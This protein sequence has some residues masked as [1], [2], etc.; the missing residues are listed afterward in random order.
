MH[1]IIHWLQT[2]EQQLTEYTLSFGTSIGVVFTL[3]K[4]LDWF[5]HTI[6]ACISALAVS[7]FVYFGMRLIKKWKP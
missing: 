5:V 7:A 6:G 2:H 1:K 3:Q 4:L